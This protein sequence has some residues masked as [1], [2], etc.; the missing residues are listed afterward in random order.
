MTTVIGLL[1]GLAI[2]WLVSALIIYVVGRLGLGMTVDGFVPAI[3][4]ALVI[5]VIIGIVNW[6]LG[7]IGIDLTGNLSIIGSIVA[8]LVSA[9]VL[10]I[11]DRFVKGMKVDG[12]GGA[13]VAAIAIGVGHWIVNWI[14]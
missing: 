13:I 4:A 12:F 1:I 6:L 7:L 9:V 3:V 8:L 10:L 5:S 2:V 14:I 11:S